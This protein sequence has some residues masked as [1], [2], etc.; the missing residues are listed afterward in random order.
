[1]NFW[2]MQLHPNNKD[3]V[4]RDEVIKIL[5]DKKIIGLGAQW[6]NDRGQPQK[7]SEEINIGDIVLIRSDGPLALVKVTGK[8]IEND[9]DD[10]WF[11][12]IRKIEVI[13][14]DGDLFKKQFKEQFK[15]NWN[16]S[17]YLPTT[18]E[19]ANNSTF[20]KFWYQTVKNKKLMEDSIKLLKYKNQIILQ[21][22]PGTGKTRQA[23]L[24]AEELTK[25]RTVG[26]PES[27]IDDLVKNFNPNDEAIK[28]SRES[29]EK[30]LSTFYELFPKENLKRLTLQ[31][32]CA[33]KGDRDNFCW[34]IERG[35]KPLGYYFPG[36]ARAYLIFWKKELEDY[37][38][39]GIVKDIE[40]NDEAMKKVAELISEVVQTK[41]TNT[42]VQ[43][44]GDSFLLKLLNSYYPDEYFPINSERMIDNALKI[45]RV[46]YQGLNVFEK[47][48]KLNQ[49]YLDKK[50]Q[51]NSQIN[52][53]EFARILFDKFNIKTGE[54]IDLKTGIV[55]EGE[56]EIIQFHPAYSYE[57]FVRGIVAETT[58]SGNVSYQVENKILADFAQKATDNPNGNYV[59]IID[60]INRANLPSVLGELIYAL[61]YR[62][63]TVTSMYEYEGEREITLPKNLFIIGTMNTADRSVGHIDYAIRRRFAFVD[64]L[65][66]ENVIQN[67]IAKTLFNEIKALFGNEFLSPDFKAKDVMIGHSYFIVKDEDELKIKLEFE[68]KPILREYLKDG[69][70]LET[71]ND[72]IEILNV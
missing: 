50:K 22:P 52:S 68:I 35:L 27:I 15:S 8:C 54:S 44:F 29:K 33:G 65:P 37:S 12:L 4:N 62:N 2:H 47:N 24:I 11:E 39:H 38:K 70:F 56:F 5:T 16:D 49:V 42:A 30:L 6:E 21:G 3:E 53:F 26:N 66:D 60:E 17:L 41:N 46:D 7:F 18:I 58:E 31:T 10:V 9:K 36:S 64:I 23:K 71:A 19:G 72:K 13:S 67:P 25:P 1:M 43:Y 14:L 59:L 20:I 57:D 34:W 51:F 63:E 61:E 40:D 55:A 28:T 32:Y 48:Q 69:I 45:F